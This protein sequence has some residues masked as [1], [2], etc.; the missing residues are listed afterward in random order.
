MYGWMVSYTNR[1]TDR[2]TDPFGL[3]GVVTTHI[4]HWNSSVV[5]RH[6]L[7]TRT[8]SHTHTMSSRTYLFCRKL[9]RI[10]TR[11]YPLENKKFWM[12]VL[13]RAS[14]YTPKSCSEKKHKLHKN[15]PKSARVPQGV[16][17]SPSG[18]TRSRSYHQGQRSQDQNSTPVHNYTLWVVLMHKL[19]TLASIPWAQGHS[20][21][22]Q[23][24]G[25]ISMVEG[26]KTKI[27][28]PCT[29]TLHG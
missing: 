9:G 11:V 23:G 25:H 16:D 18:N 20:Q 1:Q 24:Q 22:S 21:D 3:C 27:P 10:C 15:W 13:D 8:I 28:C 12:R 2:Q 14:W 4:D 26:H 7:R 17:S 29:T 6:Y 19:A 5:F